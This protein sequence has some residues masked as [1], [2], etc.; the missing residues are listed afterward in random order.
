MVVEHHR[1]HEQGAGQLRLDRL[2]EP[3]VLEQ[4]QQLGEGQ[5]QGQELGAVVVE[6]T[7][8]APYSAAIARHLG[9]PVFDTITLVEWLA[10]AVRPHVYGGPRNQHSA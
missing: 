7:N 10:T 9:L 4:A 8:I 3:R 5:P 6:C 2:G 1:P